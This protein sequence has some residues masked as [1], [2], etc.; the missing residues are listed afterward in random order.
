MGTAAV[1]CVRGKMTL[2]HQDRIPVETADGREIDVFN[3]V[4]VKKVEE[5]VVRPNAS[6]MWPHVEI[7][8]GDSSEKPEAVTRWLAERLSG[9]FGIDV[10]RE[11]IE[12][13][14]VESDDV[15]RL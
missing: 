13:I 1:S 2:K 9:E 3:W 6:E 12:V 8:A 5:A 11:G 10:D 4:N 14:D 15:T 7:G